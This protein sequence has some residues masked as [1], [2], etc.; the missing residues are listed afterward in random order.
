MKTKNFLVALASVCLFTACDND[1]P[2]LYPNWYP[3][4][5]I[6]GFEGVENLEVSASHISYADLENK[7]VDLG[8][9]GKEENTTTLSI[10]GNITDNASIKVDYLAKEG[11]EPAKA[12]KEKTASLNDTSFKGFDKMLSRSYIFMYNGRCPVLNESLTEISVTCD[13]AVGTIPAGEKLD[14][15]LMIFYEDQMAVVN[16]GYKKY[17]G[18]DA[19]HIPGNTNFPYALRGCR[20]SEFNSAEHPFISNAFLIQAENLPIAH[21]GY[22][23]TVSVKTKE[24]TALQ[25]SVTL[26]AL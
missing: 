24:G 5:Y 25:K 19:F 21:E 12:Y 16:S 3:D 7:T 11:T 2:D 1:S 20:L 4:S 18:A 13:K 6:I 14:H 10:I 9:Y 26:K 15:V 23:F 22:T 17:D 8:V